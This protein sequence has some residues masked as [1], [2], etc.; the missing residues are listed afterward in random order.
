MCS[1]TIALT[2][3]LG[4]VDLTPVISQRKVRPLV[5]WMTMD[6]NKCPI[7]EPRFLACSRNGCGMQLSMAY[8]ARGIFAAVGEF[9]FPNQQAR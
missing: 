9:D 5:P 3:E 1:P 7:P 4:K 6:K 8:S 2:Q